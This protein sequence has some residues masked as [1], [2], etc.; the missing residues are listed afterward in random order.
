MCGICGIVGFADNFPVGRGLVERM[1]DE[2][3]HR[4]PDA[5]DALYLPEDRLALGHRRL[6]IV[7][8]S[9]AGRQPMSNEDGTVWITYNGEV[10]NHVSLREELEGLGHRYRSN[11]DSETIV[12]LYEEHGPRCVELLDGMF[13]FAIWDTRRKE[14]LLA[15]DRVGVKPL[16]FARLPG[17]LVFGSEI[18]ALLQHPA[19]T[20]D[21]DET[22]L[23]E[24][25]TYAF[26]PP[27]RT[28][29]R[30]I[31]KLAP[32]ERI[33]LTADGRARQER[34]WSPF[35]NAAADLVSAMSEQEASE[36]V[37]ELL[38]RSI[39]KRMMSDV[40]FGVF[41]SGGLDSSIN[42]ALMSEALDRPVRTFSTAPSGHSAYDE[43]HY[44]RLIAERFQ[45]D[46]HEV[47]VDRA[48]MEALLPTLA[49]HLDEPTS[50]WTSVPQHF[51]SKLARDTG[52]PVVQVGEGADEIFHGYQGYV[53]HRRYV[54]PFQR[55]PRPARYALGDA[56]AWATTRF[57]MGVRHGEALYD[58]ARSPTPY[59]GGAL[60]FRGPLKE[61]ILRLPQSESALAPAEHLWAEAEDVHPGADLFQKMTYVELKQRLPE[62]LLMRLDKIAMASSVEGRDPFLDHE[63]VEF[64]LALPPRMKSRRGVGKYVLREAMRDSLPEEILNRPK[65]GFGTPM[66]EWLREDFGERVQREVRESTLVE[67]GL[68]DYDRI[69]RLFEAHRR[70]RGDW[71]KHLWNIYSV[72]VWHDHWIAGRH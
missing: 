6:A 55:L 30:G 2:L 49:H 17:G 19:V 18:K 47:L 35:S 66:K 4:G 28:R 61:A 69:D 5:A 29:Y 48:D 45:T 67:R 34:Y 21:L 9:P 25:L 12:H 53:D 24:Y 46:H 36:H 14:L 37:R 58:A 51:V 65:Q 7:D 13:A 50:D 3:A 38:G 71:S 39:S 23:I 70:G 32:G 63:L 42:V 1:R 56:A 57:G 60:C 26:T 44:A 59:W 54:V 11:T 41:L 31:E 40:P 10:Y 33:V 62:L 22:A 72:G 15:R 64:A 68:F 43:L 8:L 27:P 52:T 20:A 16:Y